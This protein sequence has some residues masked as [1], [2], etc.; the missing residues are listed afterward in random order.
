MTAEAFPAASDALYG[1]CRRFHVQGLDLF[2]SAATGCGFD[3]ARS[4]LDVLVTFDPLGPVD[5]ADA[6][7]GLL[8]ALEALSGRPVDLVTEA[9][10]ENPYF[11]RRGEMER[12]PLYPV[13]I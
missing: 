10:M 11:R 4:D 12:R 7:F 9:A 5:Y 2:G 13:N 6:Y 3:P 8:E 1:V